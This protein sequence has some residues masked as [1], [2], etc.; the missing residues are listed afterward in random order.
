MYIFTEKPGNF[1]LTC[2]SK[3]GENQKNPLHKTAYT[4]VNN[5]DVLLGNTS[6][7]NKSYDRNVF[8][9]TLTVK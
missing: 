9:N 7:S 6:S 2:Q 3:V 8:I 4:C 5:S 1:F